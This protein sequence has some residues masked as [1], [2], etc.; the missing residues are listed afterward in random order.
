MIPSA[1]RESCSQAESGTEMESGRWTGGSGV[2]SGIGGG[3]GGR[4]SGGTRFDVF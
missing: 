4:G 1:D 3:A 2:R